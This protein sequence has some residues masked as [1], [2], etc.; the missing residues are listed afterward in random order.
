[1]HNSALCN[2]NVIHE[3]VAKKV[4]KVFYSSSA[5]IYPESIQMDPDNP[6]LKEAMA[7]PAGPDSEYGWKSSL[8]NASICRTTV[9]MALKYILVVSIIFWTEGTWCG[10]REKHLQPCVAK[11][12]KRKRR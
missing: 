1:M 4:G 9:I 7:Y 2:L 10:G 5:C 3:A 11:S 12:L 6:G 8:V